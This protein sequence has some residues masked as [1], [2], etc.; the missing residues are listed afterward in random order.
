M[1]SGINHLQQKIE[2]D[3]GEPDRDS[4]L[5]QAM[6]CIL[7]AFIGDAAGG[8]LEF[9]R[10]QITQKDIDHALTFPGGGVFDFEPG[11][12]TDDSEM[13][14]CLFN[15]I[16]QSKG[17][18]TTKIL[19]KNYLFWYYSHP[20]DMGITTRRALNV[21]DNFMMC[22]D[23]TE[24]EF[25]KDINEVN[26]KSTS[27]GCLMRATPL[28]VFCQNLDPEEVYQTT[29][30]DVM[31]THTNK[32]C[33]DAVALYNIAIGHLIN[34]PKD[35]KGAIKRVNEFIEERKID[36]ALLKYYR[37]AVDEN[38]LE[39]KLPDPKV[40]IGYVLIG[41]SYAFHY[42]KLGISYEE[43]IRRALQL[44]GD[45]DTNAAIVGGMMGAMHGFNEIPK[46]WVDKVVNAGTDRPQ[47]ISCQGLDDFEEKVI[48]LLEFSEKSA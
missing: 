41:F 46:D 30:T 42:L 8:V 2:G 24:E 6:G 32:V 3:M 29:A 22:D 21:M 25:Y 33:I 48:K 34:N 5:N 47:E 1:I 27:N 45:T 36:K 40:D 12:L 4:K 37:Y 13:A 23:N 7:G 39:D 18:P 15:S 11:E 26:H 35:N 44:E 31:M 17:K 43:A 16:L 9:F 10:R 14:W 28:S 19:A 20:K 38:D